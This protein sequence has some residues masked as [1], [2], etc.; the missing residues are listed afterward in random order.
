MGLLSLLRKLKKSEGEA[1]EYRNC[2]LLFLN[3]RRKRPQVLF[4]FMS[5]GPHPGAGTGQRW[6]DYHS[7]EAQR[8]RRDHNHANA[9]VF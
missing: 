4:F 6:K 2:S 5:A 3:R 7:E 8:G 9:G 1:R